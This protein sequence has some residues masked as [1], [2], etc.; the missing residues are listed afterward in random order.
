MTIKIKTPFERLDDYELR[1]YLS[2]LAAAERDEDV[3]RVLSRQSTRI[4]EV[5]EKRGGLHGWWD[6]LNKHKE[7]R[8]EKSYQNAWYTAH[9]NIGETGSFLND[10]ALAWRLAEKRS[11]EAI[12]SNKLSSTI[13]LEARYALISSCL[14]NLASNIPPALLAQFIERELLT[15]SQGLIYAQQV[16]NLSQRALSL[17][18]VASYIQEPA[19]REVLEQALATVQIIRDETT[20]AETLVKLST[21]VGE[22][23]L[24]QIKSVAQDIAYDNSRIKALIGIA[25]HL[26]EPTRSEVV[27]KAFE[28]TQQISSEQDQTLRLIEL[29]PLL[30]EPLKT[31]TFRR[32]LSTIEAS[33]GEYWQAEA[34]ELFVRHAPAPLIFQ[35]QA[36][37][38]SI[39][40]EHQRTMTQASFASRFAAEGDYP[41]ALTL[42]QSFKDIKFAQQCAK[43][44][45]E[46]ALHWPK[47]KMRDALDLMLKIST[48][49]YRA[50]ALIAFIP[51]LPESLLVRVLKAAHAIRDKEQQGRI[52]AALVA[53]L[54]EQ[55][56]QEVI[57]EAVQTLLDNTISVQIRNDSL[58]RL[59][60]HLNSTQLKDVL[61]NVQRINDRKE[62]IITAAALAAGLPSDLKLF[63]VQQTISIAQEI[64]DEAE[65]S[66]SLVPLTA[67]LAEL[68]EL[69][70]ALTVAWSLRPPKFCAHALSEIA[71]HLSTESRRKVMERALEQWRRLRD[72]PLVPDPLTIIAPL[73]DQHLI[74]TAI[75]IARGLEGDFYRVT[76]LMGLTPFVSQ[77]ELLESVIPEGLAIKGAFGSSNRDRIRI[78]VSIRLAQLGYYDDALTLVQSLEQD[79]NRVDAYQEIIPYLPEYSLGQVLTAIKMI[80][81]EG[82]RHSVLGALAPRFAQLGQE[83]VARSLIAEI[84]SGLQRA[85]AAAHTVPYA[86][87]PLRTDAM[88]HALIII[89]NMQDALG[90]HEHWWQAQALSILAPHLPQ[91]LL[92]VAWPL[93]LN[94]E[95][96]GERRR[97]LTALA[98]ELAKLPHNVLYPLWAK[99][100]RRLAIRARGNLLNDVQALAPIILALGGPQ[101]TA[102]VIK[103]I[104]DIGRWW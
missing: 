48:K 98:K 101:A 57:T 71:P 67:R 89:T 42:I 73:L 21:K 82:A 5:G 64:K 11:V 81:Y 2:H 84:K 94:I 25:P 95:T 37:T 24:N 72:E 33:S 66:E 91:E 43:A 41:A 27:R 63:A 38:Q 54:P 83:E 86:T 58:T 35:A 65:R 49:Q 46:S 92:E 99:G 79:H 15:A 22:P 78:A 26:N 12:R 53:R 29:A 60:P 39:Q 20:R 1:Y 102:E 93:A 7:F 88:E 96:G 85:L 13:A 59:A 62:Q 45:S 36:I 87:E 14:N 76:A 19:S 77:S 30:T 8:V 69:D 50:D 16:P 47:S 80:N 97:A 44:L 74:S 103:T 3:H 51:Y 40:D 17:A 90:E 100:T 70:N 10:I 55:M 75:A 4:E 52:T 56:R 104:H 18:A 32:T 34:I 23:L 6:H 68:G 9:E 31:E 61:A 28:A